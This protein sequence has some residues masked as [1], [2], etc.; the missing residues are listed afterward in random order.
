MPRITIRVLPILLLLAGQASAVSRAG[1]S[2][3]LVSSQ[4]SSAQT[5]GKAADSSVKPVDLW[6]QRRPVPKAGE[7]PELED[8]AFHVIKPHEPAKDGYDWLHGIALA[9]HKGKLYASYG[10]NKGSEN[11]ATEQARG[12]VSLD[13]GKTWSRPFTIDAGGDKLAVSHGVFLS[14]KGHLWAFQGAF[15]GTRSK[16]HTRA[17]RLN[18][19]NGRW[20]K[21]G[22]VISDGFWPMQEPVKMANG[23]WIMS[24]VVVGNGNP[25]AVAIS[26]G[27]DLTRWDLVV[28]PRP[29]ETAMWGESALIVDGPCMVNI[30]RSA[31]PMA[32]VAASNDFG[33]TWSTSTESNLPMVT[34]KP[35]AGMLSTGQWYLI[36]TTTADTG[37]RRAPLTIAVTAPGEKLF[38]TIFCIRRAEHQG[39]GESSPRCSLSYPYAVE[40][41]GKLYVAYSNDGGRGGNRNSAELAVIP[42][43]ALKLSGAS[44]CRAGNTT[45]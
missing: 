20:E 7:L 37:T 25:A 39:A 14:H 29:E 41:E 5:T 13:G 11:T 40:H 38:R 24:G 6:N 43:K 22:E 27:D 35:Y 32:L 18:E 26:H 8:V 2:V 3:R 33:R 31:K 15:Y 4:H 42:V 19:Q 23:N 28:I 17:Y 16:V 34:S 12:Q 30:A 44:A 10:H 1:D 36:G 9:W 21:L 45:Q